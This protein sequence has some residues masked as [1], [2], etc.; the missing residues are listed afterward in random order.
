MF[1]QQVLTPDGSGTRGSRALSGTTSKAG[2]LAGSALGLRAPQNAHGGAGGSRS[3]VLT[4]GTGSAHEVTSQGPAWGAGVLARPHLRRSSSRK[5]TMWL[6]SST[7]LIY[8]CS[9]SS[10]RCWSL[11]DFRPSAGTARLQR[12]P[13]HPTLLGDT[14]SPEVGEGSPGQW[15]AVGTGSAHLPTLDGRVDGWTGGRVGERTNE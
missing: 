9:R 13:C 6:R 1:Q 8:W 4:A 7:V 5:S 14:A 10:S 12:Q 11:R 2:C 3:S 15:G